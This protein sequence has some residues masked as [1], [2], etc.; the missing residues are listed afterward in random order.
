M[1][2]P[3]KITKKL[4][5]LLGDKGILTEQTDLKA[6]SYDGTTNW[7]AMPDIVV[8]PTTKEQISE[9]MYLASEKE[10]PVTV[11]GAGTCLSG[12]PVPVAGGIVLCILAGVWFARPPGEE[13]PAPS[14][15]RLRPLALVALLSLALVFLLRKP[16]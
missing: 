11:R 2:L 7:Q 12:G 5:K 13:A 14:W 10:I 8:F 9:I 3:K 6:Y 1:S 4:I 15:L 16:W